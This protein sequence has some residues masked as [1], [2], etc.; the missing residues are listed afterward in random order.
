[1]ELGKIEALLDY[2]ALR[3][4]RN[5]LWKIGDVHGAAVMVGAGFSRFAA[6]ATDSTPVA[7][8]WSDFHQ[9]ML[10]E[11]YPKGGGSLSP[12]ALAEEYRAAMG[13]PAL[14]NLIRSRVRDHE[15][16]PVEIH[17]RMLSLPW[18]EVLT[19]N[20]DTLLERSVELN[21][22]LEYN[23]VRVPSDIAR[24]RSP[25]IVKLHGS[26]PSYDSFVFTEEDFRPY[27]ERSAPFVNL[28]RQSLLE[29]ELCLIGFSGDDPNFLEWS[30]WVRDQLAK[31][32]RPIRLI[33][34]LHLSNSR[35]RLLEERNITPI[36][37]AP[38]V[39]DLPEEDRYYRSV[40]IFLYY[41]NEGRP[42]KA[43]WNVT[44]TSNGI[45]DLPDADARLT[46]V[47]ELW[48][49]EREAHPGWLVTPPP[50]RQSIRSYF[51]EASVVSQTKH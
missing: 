29:N 21:P 37:L 27:P 14:E 11:L 24:A 12:L 38:L 19:T 50:L 51:S 40:E 10:E 7:P 34:N 35:R 28:A 46:R 48:G 41:L 25:R 2:P 3:Q 49:V 5:A 18:A 4:V 30:G 8:L 31:A 36:D 9:A 44:S 17:R 47:A 6:R 22:D 33:G 20:W 16:S 39:E 13:R 45:A 26:F 32:A 42:P 1:M 23:I 15:W 43:T